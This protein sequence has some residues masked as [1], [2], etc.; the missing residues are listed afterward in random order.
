MRISEDTRKKSLIPAEMV[1]E[2][3]LMDVEPD[4]SSHQVEN[5][6]EIGWLDPFPTTKTKVKLAKTDPFFNQ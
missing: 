2:L 4:P 3:G 5:L 6:S 1:K